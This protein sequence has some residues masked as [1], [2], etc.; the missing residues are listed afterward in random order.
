MLKVKDYYDLALLSRAF[1]FEGQLLVTAIRA[2]FRHR[3]TAI[4]PDTVGLSYAFSSDPARGAQW[5]AFL[6]RSWFSEE[7]GGLP[8]LVLEV[9]GFATAV[10]SEPVTGEPFKKYRRPGGPWEAL[11][12]KLVGSRVSDSQPFV[13]WAGFRHLVLICP[14]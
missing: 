9:R 4:E 11:S 6:R 13:N 8:A 14:S 5:R 3:G 7:V 12:M 2:T 1:I 10:L